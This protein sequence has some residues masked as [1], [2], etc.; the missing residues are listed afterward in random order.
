[1]I[2]SEELNK[3]LR[4]ILDKDDE[5]W[6]P[7]LFI[8][9]EAGMDRAYLDPKYSIDTAE[10]LGCCY[11]INPNGIYKRVN[12]QRITQMFAYMYVRVTRPNSTDGKVLW[13]F[14][15]S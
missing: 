8:T 10:A 7:D 5:V 6:H 9:A 1:M 2:T 11:M 3:Q 13:C 4:P 15:L 14:G 12:T